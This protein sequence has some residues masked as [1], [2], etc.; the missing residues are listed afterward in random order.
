MSPVIT[1]WP[2][3]TSPSP[4]FIFVKSIASIDTGT[5]SVVPLFIAMSW[6]KVST[7]PLTVKRVSFSQLTLRYSGN[8]TLKP[9]ARCRRRALPLYDRRSDEF[10]VVVA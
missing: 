4:S 2:R 10:D 6:L 9:L 5:F 7:L 1:M 8:V 3:S